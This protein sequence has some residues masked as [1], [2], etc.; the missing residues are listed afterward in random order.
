MALEVSD[1]NLWWQRYAEEGGANEWT[2][3]EHF[4]CCRFSAEV[5]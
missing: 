4:G 2:V 1:L 5:W 3:N